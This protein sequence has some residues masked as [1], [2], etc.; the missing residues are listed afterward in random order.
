MPGINKTDVDV[1][2]TFWDKCFRDRHGRVVL[3]Q[4]PNLPLIVWLVA[5]LATRP[6]LGKWE[7]LARAIATGAIFTWAWLELFDGD[8]YFRRAL[9]LVVFMSIF[10]GYLYR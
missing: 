8:N 2:V 5:T 4:M 7:L 9:G 1:R 10:V 3:A 6:L